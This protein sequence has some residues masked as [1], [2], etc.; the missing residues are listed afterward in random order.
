MVMNS[1]EMMK[2][3][4]LSVEP[5]INT[6]SQRPSAK[7]K[8]SGSDRKTRLA[9]VVVARELDLGVNDTQFT[10]VT[11]LGHLLRES[12]TVLG[13]D[14]SVATWTNELDASKILTKKQGQLPDVVIVRKS[15]E[16]KG[17]KGDRGWHLR[18]LETQRDA[19]AQLNN[20]EQSQAEGDYEEFLDQLEADK[21]LR[22]HVNI[23]KTALVDPSVIVAGTG[24]TAATGSTKKGANNNAKGVKDNRKDGGVAAD[25]KNNRALMDVSGNHEGGDEDDYGSDDERL[26]L[27]ELLDDLDLADEEDSAEDD[28][29]VAVGDEEARILSPEEAASTASY[30]MST[31]SG[32]E[33]ADF[34]GTFKFT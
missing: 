31:T 34:H 23:Y 24:A 25:R 18:S 28:G 17:E 1:R 19:S 2:Y 3:V 10:C 9:E 8:I 30:Q 4:V 15:Y 29:L 32:F 7:K 16:A 14:L 33:P 11:H 6:Q 27:D 26:R 22:G 13:Y 20:R 21:E 12:D 5:L